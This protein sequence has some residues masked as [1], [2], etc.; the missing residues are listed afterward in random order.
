MFNYDRIQATGDLR[1]LYKLKD[2]ESLPDVNIDG[3]QEHWDNIQFEVKDINEKL[4]RKQA[5]IYDK[6][7]K[8]DEKHYKLV[9]IQQTL[10]YLAR[11]K[12]PEIIKMLA[13]E[14]YKIDEKKD[15]NNELDRIFK[16]SRGLITMRDLIIVEL[17]SLTHNGKAVD[18][19]ETKQAIEEFYNMSVPIDMYTFSQKEWL[20][21]LHKTIEK[22]NKQALKDGRSSK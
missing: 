22:T 16:R 2:F 17:D 13:K 4:N 20:F 5:I 18:I 9:W 10:H 1:Y 15:Y 11:V 19:I 12:D 7:K 3:L 14:G 6:A 8:A 21:K